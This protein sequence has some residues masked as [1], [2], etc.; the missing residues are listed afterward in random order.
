V[1]SGHAQEAS[2]FRL[3]RSLSGSK[4]QESGGRFVIDDPRTVFQLPEDKQVVIYFQWQGPP[5]QHHIEVSWRNPEGKVVTTARL[6][7]LA[8]QGRFGA[9][10]SMPLSDK[11]TPGLWALE[12]RI[13]GQPA[14][15]HTIQVVSGSGA[16]TVSRRLLN[17]GTLYERAQVATAYVQ[18]LNSRGEVVAK[19]SG[20]FLEDGVLLTPFHVIDGASALVL[21]LH[22][23]RRFETNA[24]V[25]WNRR[26][27]WVLLRAPRGTPTL[28]R[29]PERSWVVGDRCFSLDTAVGSS[30]VI[31]ELSIAG[32]TEGRESGERLILG[33]SVSPDAAGSPLLNEYGEVV[34]MTGV[35][36]GPEPTGGSRYGVSIMVPQALLAVPIDLVP[37]AEDRGTPALLADLASSGEFLPLLTAGQHVFQASFGRKVETRGPVPILIDQG[38]EFSRRDGQVALWVMWDPKKRLKTTALLRVY[39]LDN[40]LISES[41]PLKM[42]LA[43]GPY[44]YTSWGLRVANFPSATYR[45][46]LV[47]GSEPGWRGYV[48]IVD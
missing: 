38:T 18:K 5:G 39:D 14:G 28:D 8:P 34:G 40:K 19:A 3:L 26:Q 47:V 29:A 46:D 22:D 31:S 32:R 23:G 37:R 24:V 16:V 13:D 1:Q 43:A 15:V 41:K 27:D 4:G 2:R 33:G 48:R 17:T 35:N 9:Y 30:R 36:T 42:D 11:T 10:W 7:Q 21:T 12:A 25:A 45:I 44:S 20:F 6:D